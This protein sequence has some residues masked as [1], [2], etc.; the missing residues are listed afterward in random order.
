MPGPLAMRDRKVVLFDLG[1]V[2]VGSAGL[3]ALRSLLPHLSERQVSE[4]WHRSRAVRLFESGRISPAA[5][6][7]EFVLEWQLPLGEAQFTASFATWVTGPFDGA[8]ALLESLRTRHVVACLSNTN[9]IH[10]AQLGELPELFDTCLASH[11]TGFMKPDRQAYEHAL[12]ELRVAADAVYF[13]DDLLPNVAAARNVGMRAFQ[14]RG[15][16]DLEPLLR[17]EGLHAGADA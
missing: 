1:G 9:A 10:W 7:A 17:A 15:F 4:R 5:F 16:A 3:A 12:H 14:V 2:L 13:F 6:A 8:R 11:L